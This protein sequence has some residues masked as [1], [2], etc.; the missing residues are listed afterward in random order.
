MNN[1]D[2]I[3]YINGFFKNWNELTEIQ[4]LTVIREL[5]DSG[6]VNKVTPPKMD[7]AIQCPVHGF[8]LA[9]PCNLSSCSY[10]VE[11]FSN[12]NCLAQC[13]SQSKTGRLSAMEVSSLLNSSVT[14]INAVS[15]SAA[16]KIRMAMIQEKLERFGTSRFKYIKGHCVHCELN[17]QPELEI[18]H[19]PS[20]F[21]EDGY[22][23]CGVDCKEKKPKWQFFLEH[24]FGV[25]FLEVIKAAFSVTHLKVDSAKKTDRQTVQRAEIARMET[26]DDILGLDSGMTYKIK[27]K[28]LQPHATP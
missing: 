17:I 5:R 1:Q 18:G 21:I 9:K 13:I 8:S 28:Y 15:N 3:D 7:N 20:L 6:V 23:W 24:T 11:S 10:Y 2:S 14:E 25:S 4:K 26:I 12:K 16:K 27:S 22:G 19:D